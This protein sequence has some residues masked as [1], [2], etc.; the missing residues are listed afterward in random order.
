MQQ[1]VVMT[2]SAIARL[3]ILRGTFIVDMLSTVAWFAQ[4][5]VQ[6]CQHCVNDTA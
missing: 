4:V 2:W 6:A 5:R 3:Y 1:R